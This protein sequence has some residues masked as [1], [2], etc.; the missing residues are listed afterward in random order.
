MIEKQHRDNQRD[1]E[2]SN[3]KRDGKESLSLIMDSPGLNQVDGMWID[4]EIAINTWLGKSNKE[5]EIKK[6]GTNIEVGKGNTKD[7]RAKKGKYKGN[8]GWKRLVQEVSKR[9]PLSDFMGGVNK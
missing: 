9:S 5:Q 4:E 1:E 3:I 7:G 2:G 6:G 8:R